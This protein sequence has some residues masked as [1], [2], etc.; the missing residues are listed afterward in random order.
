ML[1]GLEMG[2]Y[3]GRMLE[4]LL[5]ILSIDMAKLSRV[6]RLV[7]FAYDIMREMQMLFFNP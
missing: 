3:V 1:S 6:A 4:D 2:V 5:I 7:N